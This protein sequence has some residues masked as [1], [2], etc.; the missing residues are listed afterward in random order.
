MIW[1]W[2]AL[3]AAF[4]WSVSNI[5]DRIIHEK[6]ITSSVLTVVILSIFEMG[7]TIPLIPMVQWDA[8]TSD[9][10]ILILASAAIGLVATVFYFQAIVSKEVS[11]VIPTFQFIP[12]FVL[13]FAAVFFGELLT[14]KQGIAFAI[15]FL[16]VMFLSIE[17]GEQLKI[18]LSRAF[19]LAL[20]ASAFFALSNVILAQARNLLP[21]TLST[22]VGVQIAT[23]ILI[24]FYLMLAPVHFKMVIHEFKTIGAKKT[25]WYAL[26]VVASMLGYVLFISAL[27]FAP[28]A[29][30]SVIGGIQP[31]FV[32]LLAV[33]FTAFAPQL[34]REDINY[35]TVILKIVALI[36]VFSGTYLLFT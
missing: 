16:G 22:F 26:S 5:A 28:V 6:Y 36:I 30:I 23:F 27:P 32:F 33:L 34:I 13:L 25:S 14:E 20:I 19:W 8:F 15:I 1:I 2:F 11:R 18:K 4:L 35:R 7:I 29:L 10:I 3:A 12:V 24:L 17:R 21:N 9:I 31:F